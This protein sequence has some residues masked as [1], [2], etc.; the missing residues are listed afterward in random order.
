VLWNVDPKDFNKQ[1][2]DEV[3]FFFDTQPFR[4]GDIVLFHDNH[5]HAIAVLPDLIVSARDRG[6]EFVTVDTWTG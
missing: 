6:L 5:P 1:R 3:R 4:S 2:S